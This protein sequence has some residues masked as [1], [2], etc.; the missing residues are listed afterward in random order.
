[1]NA[2]MRKDGSLY[3]RLHD[4]DAY[5]CLDNGIEVFISPEQV[6]IIRFELSKPV[7]P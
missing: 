6:D 7:H 3:I 2:I 4:D 1:M 5:R